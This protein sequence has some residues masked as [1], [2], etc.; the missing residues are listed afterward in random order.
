MHYD[1]EVCMTEAFSNTETTVRDLH[2]HSTK[3]TLSIQ[4]ALL[5]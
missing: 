4:V 5:H 3:L 1:H 2:C